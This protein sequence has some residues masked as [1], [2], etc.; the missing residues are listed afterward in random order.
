[1]NTKNIKSD[2]SA[3]L[4]MRSEDCFLKINQANKMNAYEGLNV[5]ITKNKQTKYIIFASK[6]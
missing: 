4:Q 2:Y 6:L 1:M 3:V 5:S